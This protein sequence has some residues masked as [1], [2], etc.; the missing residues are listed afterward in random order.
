LNIVFIFRLIQLKVHRDGVL[1]KRSVLR[2]RFLPVDTDSIDVLTW[3]C[4]TVPSLLQ[5]S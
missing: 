1:E 4:L 2:W 5:L 3:Q